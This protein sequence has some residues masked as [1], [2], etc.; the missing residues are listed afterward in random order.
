MD[1]LLDTAVLEDHFLVVAVALGRGPGLD[2]V[3]HHDIDFDLL[4]LFGGEGK[5]PHVGFEKVD[6]FPFL[7][8][9]P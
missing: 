7:G 9:A 2:S 1:D 8:P 5:Q 3:A 6:V 4:S